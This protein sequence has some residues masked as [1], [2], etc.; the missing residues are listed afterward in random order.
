MAST[1]TGLPRQE[2]GGMV[3]AVFHY[4]R[5]LKDMHSWTSKD[6]NHSDEDIQSKKEKAK[7]ILKHAEEF[8]QKHHDHLHKQYDSLD[9]H[10]L[11]AHFHDIFNVLKNW[12]PANHLHAQESFNQ[13]Y[14][15]H[16]QKYGAH[17]LTIQKMNAW[18]R[19]PR[20]KTHK[21]RKGKGK[22]KNK[23]KGGRVSALEPDSTESVQEVHD[24]EVPTLVVHAKTDEASL[25]GLLRKLTKA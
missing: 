21:N 14:T 23:D 17:T 15:I 2:F 10:T 12:Y 8:K 16:R 6:M 18:Y 13:V 5:R 11:V 25:Q 9:D 4:E 1:H 20:Y 3:S 24:D 19:N 22:N 7:L